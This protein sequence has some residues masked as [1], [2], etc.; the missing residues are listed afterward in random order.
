[1]V[2]NTNAFQENLMPVDLVEVIGKQEDFIMVITQSGL[3]LCPK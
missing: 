2:I 3:V 1:M